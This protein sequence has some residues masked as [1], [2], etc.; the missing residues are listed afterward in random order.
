MRKRS[1][2]YQIFIPAIFVLLLFS[3][4][5][6]SGDPLPK[7]SPLEYY[8]VNYFLDLTG[9][10]DNLSMIFYKPGSVV[11]TVTPTSF[12]W[13]QTFDNFLAGDSVGFEISFLTKPNEMVSWNYAVSVNKDGNYIAGKSGT[14]DLTPG[15]TATNINIE[16][17]KLIGS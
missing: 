14:Q 10:Y 2:R 7:P 13:E 1:Y 17:L 3:S 11:E 15:E 8:D 4:C 12:P 9:S 6:K 16:W 5:D